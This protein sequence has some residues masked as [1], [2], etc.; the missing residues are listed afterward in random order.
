MLSLQGEFM[1]LLMKKNFGIFTGAFDA[2]QL[3]PV[4]FETFQLATLQ[5][6]T[7]QLATITSRHLTTCHHYISS[8]YNSTPL[9]F[10]II[11]FHPR[12]ISPPLH[13]I[14]VTFRHRYI[15]PTLHFMSM[16]SGELSL[17]SAL[18]L[19]SLRYRY[20]SRASSP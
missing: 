9:H 7:L 18:S 3:V 13:F 11:A 16:A 2:A 1:K 14:T 12:Y 20:T 19:N 8:S 5:L 4:Q 17:V 15:S 6:V 10:A